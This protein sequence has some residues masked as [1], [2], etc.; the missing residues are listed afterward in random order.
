MDTF[1]DAPLGGT[2][3]L[4]ALL[5][6]VGGLALLD[7]IWLRA[8]DIGLGTELILFVDT[9]GAAGGVES[10]GGG[11]VGGGVAGAGVGAGVGEHSA[12][13][14]NPG[15]LPSAHSAILGYLES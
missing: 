4:A 12:G 7:G 9:A 1:E 8:C 10:A 2:A 11:A 6:P 5:L 13:V 3:V 15:L 14:T